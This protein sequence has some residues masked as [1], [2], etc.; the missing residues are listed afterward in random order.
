MLWGRCRCKIF[1]EEILRFFL[2]YLFLFPSIKLSMWFCMLLHPLVLCC[3]LSYCISSCI[4]FSM[5]KY[6][7]IYSIIPL[8][9][10]NPLNI[11]I[12]LILFFLN[13]PQKCW[14][15]LCIIVCYVPI[16]ACCRWKW[17]FPCV[18]AWMLVVMEYCSTSTSSKS[19]STWS[20][21][22]VSCSVSSHCI[23][24]RHLIILR[25]VIMWL[26]VIIIRL[27]NVILMLCNVVWR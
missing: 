8:L 25:R 24:L 27:H 17:E 19:S 7:D 20:S 5:H 22:S 11:L 2:E 18:V 16:H 6:V 10:R 4:S 1:L 15:F 23:V 13:L 14:A 12:V 3:I 26:D 9:H 21:T